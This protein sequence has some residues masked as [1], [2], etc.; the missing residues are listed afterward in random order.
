MLWSAV[1]LAAIAAAAMP[2]HAGQTGVFGPNGGTPV[3]LNC[4]D[5]SWLVGFDLGATEWIHH[6]GPLCVTVDG[7]G[8]WTGKPQQL[9]WQTLWWEVKVVPGIKE[10]RLER[11]AA[12]GMGS[13][14]EGAARPLMCP[15]HTL[16]AG[17]GVYIHRAQFVIGRLNPSCRPLM[18]DHETVIEMPTYGPQV[19][20]P[21]DYRPGV[22]GPRDVRNCPR[23]EYA[24]GVYGR[25]G[26]FLDQIGF[27][28]ARVP[29]VLDRPASASRRLSTGE[30]VSPSVE[31]QEIK[32][33]PRPVSVDARP[34]PETASSGPARTPP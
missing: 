12:L 32:T 14:G 20:G 18:V 16:L 34:A 8:R 19:G 6:L 15:E 31:N 33:P 28:C 17:F 25:S 3:E 22:Y 21:H 4:P 11:R 29:N 13:S 10:E 1:L 9:G 23:G 5:G 2:A 27:N 30:R 7:Q 24:R 26:R